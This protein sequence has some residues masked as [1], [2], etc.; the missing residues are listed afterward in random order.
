MWARIKK[1]NAYDAKGDRNKAVYEYNKAVQSG[2]NYDDALTV[3]KKFL[4][5][6]YDPKA[7]QAGLATSGITEFRVQALACTL[8]VAAA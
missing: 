5:T 4:A 6:P 8:S 7:A 1:G 3:A 2:I